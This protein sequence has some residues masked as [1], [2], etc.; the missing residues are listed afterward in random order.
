MVKVTSIYNCTPQTMIALYSV[1][2]KSQI[3]FWA[4]GCCLPVYIINFLSLIL[5][6]DFSQ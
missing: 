6:A 2:I 4:L 5:P 1:I 3:Y